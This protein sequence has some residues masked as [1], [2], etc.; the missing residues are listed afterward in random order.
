MLEFKKLP[1]SR[2]FFFTNTSK[3]SSFI[4]FKIIALTFNPDF[5]IEVLPRRYYT[6]ITNVN[7]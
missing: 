2:Q 5:S 7:W 6:K 1:H 4:K 3:E